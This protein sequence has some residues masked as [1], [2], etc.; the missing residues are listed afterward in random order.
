M[1]FNEWL[2]STRAPITNR[3]WDEYLDNIIA[4]GCIVDFTDIKI[5]MEIAYNA[6]LQNNTKDTQ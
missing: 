6:A 1:T 4:A 3:P 5:Y 2:N